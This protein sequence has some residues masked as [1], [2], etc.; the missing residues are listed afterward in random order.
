MKSKNVTLHLKGDL[1][2]KYKEFCKE[3]GWLVSRQ[4][5]LMMEAQMKEEE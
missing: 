1:Y 2:D 5:E 3:K 4:V